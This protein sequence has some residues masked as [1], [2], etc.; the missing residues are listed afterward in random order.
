M[1]MVR[2]YSVAAGLTALAG[3]AITWGLLGR[4]ATVGFADVVQQVQAAKAARC[5]LTVL[6]V[7]GRSGGSTFD[8]LMVEPGWIVEKGSGMTMITDSEKHKMVTL[9]EATR[10]ALVVDVVKNARSGPPQFNLLEAFKSV[11]EKSSRRLGEKELEGHHTEGFAFSKEG[12]QFEVWADAKTQLPVEVD[13]STG[14]SENAFVRMHARFSD[15]DW[16]PA[17]DPAELTTV[18]PPGY[19]VTNAAMNLQNPTQQ[20]VVI[21]LKTFGDMNDGVLPAEL[22]ARELGEVIARKMQSKLPPNVKSLP[23]A[24]RQKVQQQVTADAMKMS[25]PIARG[26]TF[27]GNVKNGADWHYAGGASVGEKGV[28]VLWYRPAGSETWRV[29]DADG[30]VHDQKNPP[31]G[32]EPVGLL[33]AG[34]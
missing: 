27:M 26:W 7:D 6:N 29:I 9:T 16:N 25:E 10:Q 21:M 31:A 20:D 18:V 30:A 11:D 14:A 3:L 32:G 33:G 12:M 8:L 4:G 28:A 5:T 22:G 19:A 17:Y 24:E 23:A 13:L 2:K 34:K 1:R 15:F